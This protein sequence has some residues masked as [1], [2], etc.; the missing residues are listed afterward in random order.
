MCASE[1]LTI[2][3]AMYNQANSK[4]TRE[5]LLCPSYVCKPGAQLYGM[6]NSSGFIDYLKSTME[7]TETFVVEANKGRVPE[8][9]FRF[10]GNCAKN[11][12]G[13]WDKGEHECGLI[14]QVITIVDNAETEKLQHCAIREKCRWFRQRSGLACAQCSEVIRNLETKALSFESETV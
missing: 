2:P 10:A 5:S 4:E 14:D 6:V 9:R 12:C 11:G 13:H 7:I 1:G 8:K 3:F